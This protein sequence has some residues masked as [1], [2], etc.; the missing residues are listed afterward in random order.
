MKPFEAKETI[1]SISVLGSGGWT[2]FEESSTFGVPLYG[3]G[4]R[5]SACV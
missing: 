3:C 1:E 4:T 5:I 2:M